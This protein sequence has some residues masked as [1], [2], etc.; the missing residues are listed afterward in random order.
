MLNIS[1]IIYLLKEVTKLGNLFW[2]L[3]ITTTTTTEPLA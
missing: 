2:S 1:Q 3:F